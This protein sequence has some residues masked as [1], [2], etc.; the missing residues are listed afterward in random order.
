MNLKTEETT[1][2]TDDPANTSPQWLSRDQIIWLRSTGGSTD[3]WIGNA[4]GDKLY[5]PEETQERAS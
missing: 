2:F 1:L 5:A 3:L 4:T